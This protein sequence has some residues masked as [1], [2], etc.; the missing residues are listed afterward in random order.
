MRRKHLH[1]ARSEVVGQHVAKRVIAHLPYEAGGATRL[2]IDGGNVGGAPAPNSGRPHGRVNAKAGRC[3]KLDED[4]LEEITDGQ[5]HGTGRLPGVHGA[6]NLSGIREPVDLWCRAFTTGRGGGT[7]AG[8]VVGGGL[9]DFLNR[10]TGRPQGEIV[11]IRMRN[12][13]K[14]VLQLCNRRIQCRQ[15]FVDRFPAVP[16]H[17]AFKGRAGRTHDVSSI[18]KGRLV[19]GHRSL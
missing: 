18:D 2:R 13:L 7:N 15:V 1:A 19:V 5:E 3:P 11:G 14:L 4:L 8:C 16:E 10:E 6:W 17:L 12:S 9:Q